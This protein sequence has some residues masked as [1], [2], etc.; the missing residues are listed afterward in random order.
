[1]H[2]R[3]VQLGIVGGLVIVIGGGLSWGRLSQP[4]ATKVP[5]ISRKAQSSKPVAEI[6]QARWRQNPK[7]KYA[8]L[9]YYAVKHLKIQRWQEVSDFERGWQVEIYANHGRPKYLV[10]P[11]QHIQA[12]AKQLQPNW[13]TLSPDGK[14]TYDSFGVHSFSPD[15]TA[16]VSEATILKQLQADHA[17]ARIH[18]MLPHLTVVRHH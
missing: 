16:T 3:W 14:V 15:L 10:W 13:F 7:L 2:K 5:Q 9:I 18:A 4:A 1:M 8:S 6:T 17:A 12:P 11:D